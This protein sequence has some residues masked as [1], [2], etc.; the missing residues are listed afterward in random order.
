[1]LMSVSLWLDVRLV[2]RTHDLRSV[3]R[4]LQDEFGMTF[5]AHGT[6]MVAG[7]QSTLLDLRSLLFALL[8]LFSCLL[9]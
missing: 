3:L 1:M 5:I 4:L 7:Q 8:L 6:E 9:L 2:C